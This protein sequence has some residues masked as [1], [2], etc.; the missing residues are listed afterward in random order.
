MNFAIN[1]IKTIPAIF[2]DDK[3]FFCFGVIHFFSSGMLSKKLTIAELDVK[4]KRVLMRVDFNVPLKD[5]KVD[6]AQRIIVTIPTIKK[7]FEKD[8]HSLVL[9]SHLGRPNGQKKPELSLKPVAE[10]LKEL[11]GI[12]VDFLP[13]CVGEEVEKHC[14]NP[15]KGSLILLENLRFHLEEEGA[16]ENDKKEK[17]EAKKE[18]IQKFRDSLSKL[19]DVYIND[20]FGTAHR[21][22]SSMVGV[23]LPQRAAGLLLKKEL[24]YFSKTLENPV[25][26]YLAILGGK[27]VA[28]KILTIENLLDIVDEMIISGEEIVKKI[29]KKAEEKNVK[30]HFP[31][32]YIISDK[33]SNDGNISVADDESGIPDGFEGFD[34]GEKSRAIFK[35]VILKSKTIIWNGPQGVFELEKF[36][37]GTKA[38]LDA[39]VEATSKG[40]V[41]VVGGGDTGN[42]IIKCGAGDKVSLLSSG[43][44]ASIE[45]IEGKVLPGVTALSDK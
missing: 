1:K 2:K 14:A 25:K 38:V 32:D 23:N 35:E 21:A 39:V 6:D 19:G 36:A 3:Q 44:G 7:V 28:D 17:L 24:E 8:A 34:C 5:G 12:E 26:P 42:F 30:I 9:M 33:F 37:D 29:M 22:H 27:K 16:V 15:K 31:V 45:L 13:D 10:K 11:M 18:D 43:G 40:A 4:D 20:A 41:S